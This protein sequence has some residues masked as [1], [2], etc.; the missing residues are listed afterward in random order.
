[1]PRNGW[2][3]RRCSVLYSRI[4]SSDAGEN[5][6]SKIMQKIFPGRLAAE[7]LSQILWILTIKN[8]YSPIKLGRHLPEK[9]IF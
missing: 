9:Y 3:L 8:G 2:F 6:Y 7:T 5:R 1:M 4:T